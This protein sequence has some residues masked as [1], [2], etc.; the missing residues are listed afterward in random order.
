LS[1]AHVTELSGFGRVIGIG[2]AIMSKLYYQACEN[3]KYAIFRVLQRHLEGP[4][5]VLEIGSG[6]GQHAVFFAAHLPEIQW[7]PTDKSDEHAS[8]RAWIAD[9]EVVNV[10]SP[11]MLDV[12]RTPWPVTRADAVF[13]ANITHVVPWST[14]E[15]MMAGV[16]GLLSSGGKFFLYGPLNYGGE[17]TSAGNAQFDQILKRQEPA[18]G[19]RDSEALDQLAEQAGMVLLEDNVMPANNR[20]LVWVRK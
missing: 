7:Q 18:W 14:V 17:Y 5:D 8:I 1:T 19:I 20:L 2:A 4:G 12:T 10:N 9:T 15:A 16:G 3:N 11:L 6:T 13:S